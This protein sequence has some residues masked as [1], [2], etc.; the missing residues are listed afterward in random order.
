[1][2]DETYNLDEVLVVLDVLVLDVVLDVLESVAAL[3][4]GI[5]ETISNTRIMLMR[6]VFFFMIS[7]I[8]PGKEPE[9]DALFYP[10]NLRFPAGFSTRY[11]LHHDASRATYIRIMGV[12]VLLTENGINITGKFTICRNFIRRAGDPLIIYKTGQIPHIF[13]IPY[14][15]PLP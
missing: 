12:G 3:A 13:L 14:H 6:A 9:H 11:N 7:P 4:N 10:C 2:T 15:P 1:V 8:F 5:T